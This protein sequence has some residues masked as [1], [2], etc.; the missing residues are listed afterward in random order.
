MDRDRDDSHYKD[1]KGC[2]GCAPPSSI[3][4][5]VA[6]IDGG[7]SCADNGDE[8]GPDKPSVPRY[9]AEKNQHGNHANRYFAM[10]RIEDGKNYVTA[11]EL[12]YWEEVHG[13]D[14]ETYPPRKS[15]GMEEYVITGRYRAKDKGGDGIKYEGRAEDE[16]SLPGWRGED[17]G[18]VEPPKGNG[19]GDD[20][21]GN[22]SRRP[23]IDQ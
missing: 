4:G 22:R 16:V 5:Y 17:R 1:Q 13:G 23:Y 10:E 15:H 14:K 8:D 21:A 12:P 11:I 3:E 2:E 7:V 6:V 18:E 20:E 19:D 9:E